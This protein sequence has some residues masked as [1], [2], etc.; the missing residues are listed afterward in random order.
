[1]KINVFHAGIHHGEESLIV[2]NERSGMVNFSGCHLSC[3]FCYTP[4]TSVLK[5]GTFYNTQSFLGLLQSLVDRG[6]KNIN[7]ISPTHLWEAIETPL[8]AFRNLHPTLPV[9]LKTSGYEPASLIERFSALSDVLV[10]DFKIWG[11]LPA[12]NVNLPRNYGSV[13]LTALQRAVSLYPQRFQADGKLRQGVLV[14]HLLMPNAFEDS[15]AVID[16]L[17]SIH[18]EGTL[19]LMS[20]FIDPRAHSLSIAREKDVSFLADKAQNAGM[21]VLLNG[22]PLSE[23][24]L[25][26]G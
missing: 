16:A 3:N 24:V 22:K 21:M 7:L 2:G 15:E 5:Q 14:R 20:R 11:A 8:L 1:M 23:R 18:F 19:N 12:Q 4:E 25:K 26:H 17:S 10:P 6:A 13:A 9:V